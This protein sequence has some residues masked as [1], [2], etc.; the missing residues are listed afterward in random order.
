MA[1]VKEEKHARLAPSAA[2][3]WINCPASVALI[4][5]LPPQRAGYAAAEG[6]VAHKLH[7]EYHEGKI[8]DLVL[9]ARIGTI[10]KQEGHDVEITEEMYESALEYDAAIKADVAALEGTKGSAAVVHKTEAKVAAAESIDPECKGTADKIVYKKGKKLIVRDLKFGRGAVEVEDNEQMSVYAVATMETEA[11]WAFD[12]VELIVDQPRAKHED[13][14][15]RRW[16]TTPAALKEFAAKAKAAAAETRNPNAPLRA[17]SWCR[18]TYC[19]VAKKGCPALSGQVQASAAVA[20][21]DPVPTLL[22]EQTKSIE[23]RAAAFLA[24]RL[25]DVRLMT[26]EQLIEAYKW[27]EPTTGFFDAIEEYMMERQLAGKPV[28]GTKLVNGRSNR[29]YV[30]PDEVAQ[31]FGAVAWEKKLLSPAKLEA[32]VGKKAGVDEMTY[33]PEPK[34]LLVLSSDPREAARVSAQ[35]AF[36][37]PVLPSSTGKLTGSE[38]QLM[39]VPAE[40]ETTCPECDILG[41]CS[42]HDVQPGAV[43]AAPEKREPIW[44]V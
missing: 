17:G 36:A 41:V 4:E 9:A 43:S 37:D 28:P 44:P 29:A 12:E 40:I 32:V 31:K 3:R 6:T 30:N 35:E 26:D 22:P 7:E 42:R 19:P 10:V 34:K 16:I 5:K 20:F 27:K 39:N 13:G 33:K 24:L 18:S 15:E 21:S 2:K 38:P 14:K 1:D 11:G 8:D 23:K 25:A